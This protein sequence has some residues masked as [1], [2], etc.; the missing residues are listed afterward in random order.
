MSGFI[1]SSYIWIKCLYLHFVCLDLLP[2][3]TSGFKAITYV[4]IY[5]QYL[6]L[7]LWHYWSFP[8]DPHIFHFSSC[9]E[10]LNIIMVI[11]HKNRYFCFT[12]TYMYYPT[13]GTLL[14]IFIWPKYCRYGVKLLGYIINQSIIQWT[15]DT[16]LIYR[17]TNHRCVCC[18]SGLCLLLY[19]KL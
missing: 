10:R 14:Y 3:L 7:D 6:H 17:W 19:P 12:F 1:A 5:C 18:R 2:V 11:I 16:D 4:W 15:C 9:P 8:P 13:S